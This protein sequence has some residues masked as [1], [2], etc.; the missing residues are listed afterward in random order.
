[1]I[2]WIVLRLQA[3]IHLGV[4]FHGRDNGDNMH[5]W[6]HELQEAQ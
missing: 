5:H 2:E 4:H 1:M 6:F 3:G